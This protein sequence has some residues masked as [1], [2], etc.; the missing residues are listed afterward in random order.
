[1]YL[2][3]IALSLRHLVDLM[4]PEEPAPEAAEVAELREPTA[5]IPQSKPSKATHRDA[6]QAA[7]QALDLPQDDADGEPLDPRDVALPPVHLDE[8]TKPTRRRAK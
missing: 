7:D 3:D 2:N 6:L 1:M 8:D 5:E 4:I